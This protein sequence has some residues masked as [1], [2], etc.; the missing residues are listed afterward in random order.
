MTVNK[1]TGE[2]S[3]KMIKQHLFLF[4]DVLIVTHPKK[5]DK[6]QVISYVYLLNPLLR[7]PQVQIAEGIVLISRYYSNW[8][9]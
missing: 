7:E 4:N 5:G 8:S 2:Q 1:E 6:Y 3:L 9:R